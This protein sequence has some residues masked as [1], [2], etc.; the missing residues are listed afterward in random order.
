VTSALRWLKDVLPRAEKYGLGSIAAV[1]VFW[2]FAV[3]LPRLEKAV[4][5]NG[6]HVR[7]G[8][9]DFTR[10]LRAEMREQRAADALE[11]REE[12]DLI[13]DLSPWPRTALRPAPA[14]A[15]PADPD[16]AP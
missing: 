9:A 1:L 12:R 6:Q 4:R 10:E 16:C 7:A 13:R 11:R 15:A 5:E 2:A 3:A 8:L 14:P